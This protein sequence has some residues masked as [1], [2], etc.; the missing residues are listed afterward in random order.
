MIL[1]NI[2][3][4]F[5]VAICL[6]IEIIQISIQVPELIL[7]G[8]DAFEGQ[9]QFEVAEDVSGEHRVCGR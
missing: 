6:K 7:L 3:S 1:T 9:S 5:E 2:N 4:H 8:L